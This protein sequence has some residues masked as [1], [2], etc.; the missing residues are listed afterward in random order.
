[1]RERNECGSGWTGRSNDL[2]GVREISEYGFGG[3]GEGEV[4]GVKVKI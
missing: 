4:V 3:E 1:M 2:V